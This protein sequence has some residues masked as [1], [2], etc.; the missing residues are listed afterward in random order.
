M[1]VILKSILRKKVIQN[2]KRIGGDINEIVLDLQLSEMRI[3]TIE[4]NNFDNSIIVHVF[5]DD[6]DQYYDFD[7]LSE[8]DKILILTTLNFY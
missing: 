4:F 5:I 7:E 1:K 2:I 6:L 8:S 3:N